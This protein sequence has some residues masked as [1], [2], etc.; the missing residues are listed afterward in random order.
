MR[1]QVA[2]RQD[3]RPSDVPHNIINRTRMAGFHVV[4][5]FNNGKVVQAMT[6]S[7]MLVCQGSMTLSYRRCLY[8]SIL[9]LVKLRQIFS[10][11]RVI[12]IAAV[13]QHRRDVSRGSSNHFTRAFAA[14][15]ESKPCRAS[16][17]SHPCASP[18]IQPLSPPHQTSWG[19]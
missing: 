8:T 4:R 3:K 6:G 9:I 14:A 12:N 18:A 13:Q 2:R 16:I 11:C 19:R 7:V 15:S 17:L 10:F 1:P 5:F